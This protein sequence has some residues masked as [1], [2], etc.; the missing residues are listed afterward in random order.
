LFRFVAGL[1]GGECNIHSVACCIQ[2]RVGEWFMS[3][4]LRQFTH[5]SDKRRHRVTQAL[6]QTIFDLSFESLGAFGVRIENHIA[7]GDKGLD[8]RKPYRFKQTTE[9]VHFYSMSADI[10]GS[11]E[12]DIFWHG[13]GCSL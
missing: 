12:R 5:R 11:E 8:V 4:N 10:D 1:V 7:A 9:L 3:G 6:L 2:L 13:I